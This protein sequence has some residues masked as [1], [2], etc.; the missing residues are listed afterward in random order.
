[1]GFLNNV[2]LIFGA[3]AL[4]PIL[5]H[6]LNR[7]RVKLVYFS[8]L[9]YL[10]NLQKTRMRRL[11]IRQLL[12]LLLRMLIILLI[13]A[14]FARPALKSGFTAGLGSAAKTSAIVMIDNSLSMSAETREGSLFDI[15][16]T[17]ALDLMPVLSDGDELLLALFNEELQPVTA[18]F[19][20]D[21]SRASESIHRSQQSYSSTDAT[22]SLTGALEFYDRSSNLNRELYVISDFSEAGWQN[23][24]GG[25]FTTELPE[26]RTYIVQVS[27]AD[28]D[29]IK[30][31]SID[32]G[33]QLI[34]PGRPVEAVVT[35]S[36]DVPKRNPGV[37]TSL[38]IDGTRVSQA[39]CDLPASS[40]STVSFTHTFSEAGLHDG[41]V[42]LPDDDIMADNM[43]YFTVSIPAKVRVLIVGETE[44]DN[45]YLK[46]ALRPEEE[47]P[48]QI[49]FKSIG[50]VSVSAEDFFEYDCVVLNG[51]EFISESLFSTIDN[52]AASGG[53]LLCFLPPDG[54]MKFYGS[55]ITAKRF[56]TDIIGPAEISDGA[57]YALERL[58]TSHPIFS[59]YRDIDED[60]LPS[61]NFQKIVKLRESSDTQVLGWFSSGTPAILETEWGQGSAVLF[62]SCL[63]LESS[64]FVRHP[65]FVTFVNRSLEYLSADMTRISEQFT[66]GD[67][68]TRRVPDLRPGEKLELLSP[69]GSR[70]LLTPTM[71]GKSALL[72]IDE[73][74]L[75]GI[76]GI[77]LEDS[78]VDKIA[79][80][81]P[82]TETVQRYLA[83]DKISA[84]VKSL[85]PSI[86]SVN[87]DAPVERIRED[88]HG[89]EIW[90]PF[91]FIALG[92]L[93]LEMFIAKSTPVPTDQQDQ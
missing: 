49:E 92:L 15:G 84:Q 62:A 44:K 55:R 29:N 57:Y 90:K 23:L 45:T 69:D 51:L 74:D 77:A 30:V 43:R 2:L 56:S 14:A 12:L 10:K 61:I 53:R 67:V 46:L 82:T 26:L 47:S 40:N 38:F 58:D 60:K 66:V 70:R 89:R 8:S 78:L 20:L 18:G 75:P 50:L 11:R 93:A 54:D 25:A 71:A 39:D 73:T 42:E 7:Q 33:R 65:L 27:D 83:P 48:T 31:S 80:N 17:F 37:L 91:L 86:L 19:S 6:L 16:K 72:T 36:N 22:N 79:V 64:D 59:R 88:R 32:F 3:F 5:I 1:M 76:Y 21:I 13:V 87:D 28:P 34:Y 24:S 63:S 81:S 4:V 41:Y 85:N 9:K 68:I 52:F 35:L